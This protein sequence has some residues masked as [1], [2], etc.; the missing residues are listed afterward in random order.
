M[1]ENY[2]MRTTFGIS[3][4]FGVALLIVVGGW[5]FLRDGFDGG[6]DGNVTSDDQGEK[7][8][9]RRDAPVTDIDIVLLESFPVQVR[10]TAKGEFPDVCTD[11]AEVKTRKETNTF[12]VTVAS[13]RFK[14]AECSRT[15]TPFEEH[16]PL[17]VYGLPADIY[18]VNVNG[19]TDTF[20][21][22]VD[23]TLQK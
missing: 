21:F 1:K 12:F 16:I 23:N 20:E 4:A 3:F 7:N 13:A 2:Y 19:I 6:N 8:I 11:L 17:D 14:D 18:T 5:F 9:I 22:T 15:S 10:V